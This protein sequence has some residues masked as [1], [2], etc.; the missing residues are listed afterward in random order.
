MMMN[1]AGKTGRDDNI[2]K[3]VAEREEMSLMQEASGT[4]G[5]KEDEH[6]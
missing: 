5:R 6:N 4:E 2:E 1:T 3:A